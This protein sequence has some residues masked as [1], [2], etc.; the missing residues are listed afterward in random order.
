MSNPLEIQFRSWRRNDRRA[1]HKPLLVVLALARFSEGQRW[2]SWNQVDEELSMLLSTFC[3]DPS[4]K[5]H[6]PFIR[7]QS[8]G[9]WVLQKDEGLVYNS[10][11]DASV[12][13]LKELNP[14]GGLTDEFIASCEKN[15][16]SNWALLRIREILESEFPPSLHDE[17]LAALNVD[18]SFSSVHIVRRS[19][20]PEFRQQVLDIYNGQCAICGFSG[21]LKGKL[22]GVEAAHIKWHAY[23]G[24][25][26]IRNGLA[27]CSLH[28]KLFDLGALGLS[29]QLTVL[30]SPSF[31][32]ERTRPMVLDYE[33]KEIFIPRQRSVA[34]DPEPAYVRWQRSE[35]YQ[36]WGG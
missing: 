12:K 21:R 6:Y 16:G 4:P 17:I 14:E 25:D 29:D 32:G 10:S 27:L 3:H 19:R 20:S 33:G 13:S 31:S 30:V 5:P 36:D 11:G 34:T 2:I 23:G 24:P 15:A 26:E 8:D 9:I 7:L 28:H 22:A 35:V 1:P 18:D